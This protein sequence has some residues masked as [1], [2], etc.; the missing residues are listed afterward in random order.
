MSQDTQPT[1]QA[2]NISWVSVLMG[3][4]LSEKVLSNLKSQLSKTANLKERILSVP[5]NEEDIHFKY[6]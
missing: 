2:W 6:A 4:V 3:E 5:R 1:L